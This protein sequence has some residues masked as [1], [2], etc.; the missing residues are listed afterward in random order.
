V[1]TG[2]DPDPDTRYAVGLD[3]GDGESCL[4]WL[5]TTDP[6]AGSM[7]YQRTKPA[8]R[9]VLTA[10]A[11]ERTTGALVFGEA[12][13]LAGDVNQFVVNVKRVPSGSLTPDVVLFA[14][15][16]LDEFFQAH[17][18]VRAGCFVLVGHP[19]GWPATAR[20]DYRRFLQTVPVPLALLA[21]SQSALVHVWDLRRK[22]LAETGPPQDIDDVLVVDVGSSTVDVTMVTDLKPINIDVGAELGCRD[23]DD[24]LAGRMCAALAGDAAFTGAMTHNDAPMLLRLACRRAKE[25]QFSGQSLQLH[26]LPG[27]LNPR[28]RAILDQT[29][30]LRAQDIPLLVEQQWA[31]RFRDLLVEVRKRLERL[32]EI[33]VLTGGGSRMPTTRRICA[34][35]FP[36]ATLE[37]D[38]APSFSVARGL[39]SAGGH[40]LRALRFRRAAREVA[41]RPEVTQA[42]R[43]ATVAAFTAIRDNTLETLRKT[44]DESSWRGLIESPPG[45]NDVAHDLEEAVDRAVRPLVDQVCDAYDIPGEQRDL[46]TWL[47]PPRMFT[48]EI[49]N[50]V[51]AIPARPDLAV[52]ELEDFVP[53]AGRLIAQSAWRGAGKTALTG[54]AGL[55]AKLRGGVGGAGKAA[56]VVAGAYGVV[57][58]TVWTVKTVDRQ[59]KRRKTLAAL[60]ELQL[61]DEV[62]TALEQELAAEIARVVEERIAPLERMVR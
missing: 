59:V 18:E 21:E 13:L 17:P 60:A 31:P 62:I 43:E 29:G 26:D 15:A 9:S 32:P 28:W 1:T 40:R 3:L 46:G 57:A 8:E 12:A 27:A 44:D 23:I 42:L 48:M 5:D 35:V 39:A 55:A 2:L 33:V 52:D 25:A 38:D 4:A 53:L 50:R 61:P 34:D 58:G 19:T 30:W 10:L 24:D 14:Q 7:I 54:M 6:A 16:F 37:M 51:K 47:A 41:T 36:E 45:M 22:R 20:D 11:R 56:L 49:V